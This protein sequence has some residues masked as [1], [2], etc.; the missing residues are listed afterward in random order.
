MLFKNHL[1]LW[2]FKT[3]NTWVR[4]VGTLFG[5]KCDAP[6]PQDFF[7]FFFLGGRGGCLSMQTWHPNLTQNLNECEKKSEYAEK[8]LNLTII[9]GLLYSNLY[10]IQSQKNLNLESGYLNFTKI[11]EKNLNDSKKI[12]MNGRSVYVGDSAPGR[13]LWVEE[14]GLPVDSASLYTGIDPYLTRHTRQTLTITQWRSHNTLQSM[15]KKTAKLVCWWVTARR[16]V[17]FNHQDP[18][19][20]PTANKSPLVEQEV[21]TGRRVA[22]NWKTV[23]PTTQPD[24]SAWPRQPYCVTLNRQ[25]VSIVP[26]SPINEG[27]APKRM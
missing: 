22:S 26:C 18:P 10:Q 3:Q 1:E 25:A 9:I 24:E 6:S 17:H 19:L 15:E 5:M 12:W 16:L 4:I 27:P 2:G 20:P 23:G 21:G 13:T 11:H 7:F 8:N 14:S